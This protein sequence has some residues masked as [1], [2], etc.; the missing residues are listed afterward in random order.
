M[1]CTDTPALPSVFKYLVETICILADIMVVFG[2]FG[3]PR[4]GRRGQYLALLDISCNIP[5]V[6]LEVPD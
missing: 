3:R 4:F 2:D 5:I 6:P 1:V